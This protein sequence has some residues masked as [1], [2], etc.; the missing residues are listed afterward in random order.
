[1]AFVFDENFA[2]VTIENSSGGSQSKLGLKITWIHWSQ[3]LNWEDLE[4]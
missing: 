1:M 2:T 3:M 4:F